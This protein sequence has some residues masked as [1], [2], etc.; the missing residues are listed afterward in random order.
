MNCYYKAAYHSPKCPLIFVFDKRVDPAR[1]FGHP[2]LPH[3]HDVSPF[4]AKSVSTKVRLLPKFCVDD[5]PVLP[6]E[7]ERR[8]VDAVSEPIHVFDDDSFDGAC[9]FGH[10]TL[11]YIHDV[12]PFVA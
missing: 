3:I 11:P 9:L 1:L 6:H 8:R 5:N 12:S 2:A 4:V 10:P 7:R